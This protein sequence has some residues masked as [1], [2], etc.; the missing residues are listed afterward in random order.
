MNVY[1]FGVI[2]DVFMGEFVNVVSFIVVVVDYNVFSD[3]VDFFNDC[4]GVE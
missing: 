4:G 1:V 3:S 2:F